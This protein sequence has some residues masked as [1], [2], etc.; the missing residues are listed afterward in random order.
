MRTA[1]ALL[2]RLDLPLRTP[3]A[4]NIAMAQR[5]EA[6]LATFD[7][8]MARAARTLGLHVLP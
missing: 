4:L 8:Q 7:I 5:V 3:D 2:R 1:Q 6:A